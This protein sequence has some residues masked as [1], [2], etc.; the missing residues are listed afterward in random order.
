M[1]SKTAD[2]RAV[3]EVR[4]VVDGKTDCPGDD[5]GDKS[6]SQVSP[7]Q[8]PP[9]FVPLLLLLLQVVV[10]VVVVAIVCIVACSS[11][12]VQGARGWWRGLMV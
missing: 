9:G 7:P 8:P 11:A 10:V 1:C 2:E 5:A 4:S 6:Q 12:G 3:E